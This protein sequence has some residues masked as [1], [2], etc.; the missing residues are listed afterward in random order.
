MIEIPKRIFDILTSEVAYYIARYAN[1]HPS[2][3]EDDSDTSD[4]SPY[5][6]YE[7]ICQLKEIRNKKE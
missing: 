4:I 7:A 1:K 2:Q 3:F 5:D 6:I